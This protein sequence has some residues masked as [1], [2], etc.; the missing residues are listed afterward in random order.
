MS[1]CSV[2]ALSLPIWWRHLNVIPIC[3]FMFYAVPFLA[4]IQNSSVFNHSHSDDSAAT[5]SATRKYGTVPERPGRNEEQDKINVSKRCAVRPDVHFIMKPRIPCII[6]FYLMSFLVFSILGKLWLSV[7]TN[8]YWVGA[9]ISTSMSI[10]NELGPYTFREKMENMRPMREKLDGN[11]SIF[12]QSWL[13]FFVD[14]MVRVLF[15]V[16]T[17]T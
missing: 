8:F 9:R 5:S 13:F 1:I 14:N 15:P 3:A 4:E 10:S 2:S 6:S 12:R 7:Y 17:S 16:F 11:V